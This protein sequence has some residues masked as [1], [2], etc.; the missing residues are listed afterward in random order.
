MGAGSLWAQ[1]QGTFEDSLGQ[2][3]AEIDVEDIVNGKIASSGSTVIDVATSWGKLKL[4]GKA[5]TSL[6]VQ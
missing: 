2:A 6:L 1:T 4:F 5:S 3:A